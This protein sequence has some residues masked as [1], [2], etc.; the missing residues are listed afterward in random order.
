MSSQFTRLPHLLLERLSMG[1]VVPFI[2]SGLSINAGLPDWRQLLEGLADMK[3][4]TMPDA[5][6]AE[7]KRAISTGQY[8]LAA[9]ALSQALGG[10]LARGIG[11]LLDSSST[12][13]TTVHNLLAS[14]R[15]PAVIT[16]NYD[17][18]LSRAFAPTVEHVTWLDDSKIENVLR[19]ALPHIMFA[20]GA[21]HR[22]ETIVLTPERYRK[23]LRHPAYRTYLKVVFTHYTVLFLGFS[24]SDRDVNWL[25]EDLRADFGFSNFP[26]FALVAE[27]PDL[28]LRAP[29]LRQN[30][31]V[32]VV[33]YVSSEPL[34]S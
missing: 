18:L 27:S 34:A 11:E 28:G 24:F 2:G 4:P 21:L 19:S 22:P 5:L 30:F 16:T 1:R 3:S 25:L 14:V 9:D 29:F 8:E 15:W 10:D 26:H 12:R 31:N 13:P 33:P 17:P 20:H 6:A 7:I 23:C 32:E